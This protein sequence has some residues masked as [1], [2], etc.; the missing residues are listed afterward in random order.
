VSTLSVADREKVERKNFVLNMYEGGLFISSGGIVSV[1]T[2]LPALVARL[3]GSDVAVG[4]LSVLVFAGVFLPQIFAARLVETLPWKKP[5]SVRFGFLQRTS[6]LV[7]GIA[8]W[9]LGKDWPSLA[10]GIFFLLITSQQVFGGIATPG[11]FDFFAKLTPTQKRGRLIGIRVS[12]GGL[13]ALL[14]GG[15]LTWL[16]GH[17]AFPASYALA[18]MVASMVQFSSLAVQ[19]RLVELEP[20]LTVS[21]RPVSA[22]LRELPGVLQKNPEFKRFIISA[23]FLIPATMPVGFFTVYVL[24]RFE[25]GEA[26]VGTLTVSMV[27]IQVVSALITG[28]V[29]DHFG[30][31]VALVASGAAMLCAS[32]TAVLAPGPGWFI[33][34]F[35]FVGINAGSEIMSRY[36]IAAEFSSPE[37]RSTYVGLMNTVLAPCYGL[38]L[39]GGI[40]SQMFGYKALFLAGIACSLIGLYLLIFTV[41]DPRRRVLL[42]RP[43]SSA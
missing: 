6:L 25:T 40:I 11:W 29:A 19:S 7:N 41:K 5:W 33:L 2:V 34:V 36:N 28:Y 24:H 17:V 13:G 16:L 31:K 15:L 10:L 8:I 21:R 35:M 26:I 23:A 18:M 37:Q 20:S 1:Q 9:I 12:L 42:S 30:N 43:Q 4:A 14:F 22:Y 39:L 32:V 3:G 38:A 27:A